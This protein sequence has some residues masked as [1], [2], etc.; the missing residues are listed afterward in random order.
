MSYVPFKHESQHSAQL[1]TVV[2]LVQVCV[3]VCTCIRQLSYTRM[4]NIA[5]YLDTLILPKYSCSVQRIFCQKS[6]FF[7]CFVALR[8]LFIEVDMKPLARVV[9]LVMYEDLTYY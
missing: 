4:S 1:S 2:S 3:C 9:V 7:F 8:K 5:T 6:Q